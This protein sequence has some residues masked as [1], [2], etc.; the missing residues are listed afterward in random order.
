MEYA[1]QYQLCI[2]GI[3]LAV[4]VVYSWNTSYSSSCVLMEYALQYQL[5]TLRV[6]V[7]YAQ[8][9]PLFTPGVRLPVHIVLFV[10]Y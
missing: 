6:R 9:Y 5:C 10:K 2:H 7:E 1:L 8:Q 3:R 4:P